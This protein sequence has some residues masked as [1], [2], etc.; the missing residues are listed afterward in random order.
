MSDRE[1]AGD[2]EIGLPQATV[3]K[4]IQGTSSIILLGFEADKGT[5]MLP[6]D[7]SCTK[8]VKDVIV[9]C[10]V[11]EPSPPSPGKHTKG[12][13]AEAGQNGS[14]YSRHNQM[15]FAMRVR[16]RLS[17]LNMSLRLYA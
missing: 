9:E 4:L 13:F 2:D 12:K 1:G 14:S 17:H 8:E 16:R 5:E 7:L 15:R 10:C 6:S 11:G 3:Y